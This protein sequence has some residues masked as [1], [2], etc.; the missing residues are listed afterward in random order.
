VLRL[1]P[2]T[3]EVLDDAEVTDR[4]YDDLAALAAGEAELASRIESGDLR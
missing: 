2:A 1:D 3:G 4:S